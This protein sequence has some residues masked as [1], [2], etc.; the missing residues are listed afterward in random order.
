[1]TLRAIARTALAGAAA[2]AA[3]MVCAAPAAQAPATTVESLTVTARPLSPET[4]TAAVEAFVRSHAVVTRAGR[5][6]RWRQP[7]CPITFGAPEADNAFI[8]ARIV[9]VAKAVGAP[10][11]PSPKCRS[12]IEV[13]VTA[14]P[15]QLIDLT[16]R[17]HPLYG[18]YHYQTQI[19]ALLAFDKP[20]KSWYV[21]GTTGLGQITASTPSTGA[22]GSD[23]ATGSVVIDETW[24]QSP[25]GATGSRIDDS[26]ISELMNVLI[27]VDQKKA[28]DYPIG[29][30][31]DYAAMLALSQPPR[32]DAC[33]SL[34]SILDLLAPGCRD[35]AKPTSL[36]DNDMAYLLA[37]YRANLAL[38]SDFS[39]GTL[40]A[41]M[42]SPAP[43]TPHRLW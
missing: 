6:A 41:A 17:R 43:P 34:G 9:A 13:I 26:L 36:T 11:D 19:K 39:K 5:M 23:A 25:G 24:A 2:L 35:G 3:T 21:T 37:L 12:N 15:Q 7:I 8:T 29:A 4:R 31:A 10:V 22:P 32:R 14:Y 42:K 27:I 16:Y 20:I 40:A 30:V 18:G 33:D 38:P 28:G 1:M